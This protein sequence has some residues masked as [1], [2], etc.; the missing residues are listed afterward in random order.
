MFPSIHDILGECHVFP[1]VYVYLVS[2]SHLELL[3]CITDFS[4]TAYLNP[5]MFIGKYIPNFVARIFE[6]SFDYAQHIHHQS[7]FPH[8]VDAS[9]EY[10]SNLTGVYLDIHTIIT[11]HFP[12]LFLLRLPPAHG[13][14]PN[15]Q[16]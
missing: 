6:V 15:A 1:P 3:T 5:D 7:S 16:Q 8:L 9:W 11:R 4:N 2:S 10:S 12:D 14:T 13:P